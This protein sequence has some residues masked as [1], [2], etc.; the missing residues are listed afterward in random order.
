MLVEEVGGMNTRVLIIAVILISSVCIIKGGA[1][2]HYSGYG[3]ICYPCHDILLTQD[4]KISKL[5]R[6]SCHSENVADWRESNTEKRRLHEIHG[7][8]PCF[9]CHSGIQYTK[10]DMAKAIH[11]PHAKV[12]CSVCHGT[13]SVI[14]PVAEDCSDCHGRNVHKIHQGF[15]LDICTGCHGK[16]IN[17]FPEL[18]KEVGIVEVEAPVE[19]KKLFSLYDLI[20]FIL[21]PL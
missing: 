10:E 3:E 20:K 12:D 19:E 18:R 21:F 8:S 15:L 14:K 17:K 5:S 2:E 16:V 7:S 13:K 9:R 6:C 11:I 1:Q 4:E